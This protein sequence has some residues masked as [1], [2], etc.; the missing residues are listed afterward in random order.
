MRERIVAP[1]PPFASLAEILQRDLDALVVHLLELIFELIAPLGAAGEKLDDMRDR[2]RRPIDLFDLCRRAHVNEA[3]K[4][5]VGNVIIERPEIEAAQRLV[6]DAEHLRPVAFGSDVVVTPEPIL[7][8]DA[9]GGGPFTLEPDALRLRA[10]SRKA[11][12]EWHL[13]RRDE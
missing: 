11:L 6:A 7:V 12:G 10:I 1:N 13:H 8:L 2:P 9:S 3:V 5:I 4:I